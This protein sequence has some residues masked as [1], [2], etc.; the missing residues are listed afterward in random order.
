MAKNRK[1][2]LPFTLRRVPITKLV[3]IHMETHPD[4]LYKSFELQ[5]FDGEPHGRGYRVLAYRLDHYVDIYDSHDLKVVMEEHLN[6]VENGLGEYQRVAINN[7]ALEYGK[8]GFYTHFEFI[9]KLGRNIEIHIKEHTNKETTSMNLLAPLGCSA[10]KPDC[11]PMYLLYQYDFVRKHKTA[12]H[13]LINGVSMTLDPF[14]KFRVKNGQRRE[15]IKYSMDAVLI[16]FAIAQ[17]DTIE[18]VKLDDNYSYQEEDTT[19]FFE[20]KDEEMG[21]IAIEY[22]D[23]AHQIKINF[24]RGLYLCGSYDMY[25]QGQITANGRPD[26]GVI[27]GSYEYKRTRKRTIL[28]IQ[29][30]DG[31]IPQT[32][33]LLAKFMLGKRSV[34]R[35]WPE[36]YRYTQ[37]IEWDTMQTHSQWSR[38][39]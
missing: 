5:Y 22:D 24:D 3:Q 29:P 1:A 17:K 18:K 21:L 4:N 26:I 33:G 37:A 30:K 13:V 15:F 36:T 14:P 31:W 6:I 38:F 19:Y 34:F 27:R 28:R 11:F 8:D 23:G 39:D 32:D 20:E 7:V 9:D 12:I 2:V 25:V 35:T 10:A 16:D